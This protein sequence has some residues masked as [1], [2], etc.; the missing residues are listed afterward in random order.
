LLAACATLL[1]S[2]VHSFVSTFH[3]LAAALTSIARAV[4]PAR[5]S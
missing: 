1:L 4:A 3:S 2:V 5:R